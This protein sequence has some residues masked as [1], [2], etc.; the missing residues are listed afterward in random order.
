MLPVFVS[1]MELKY[2][3]HGQLYVYLMKIQNNLYW[4][5]VT[6]WNVST[7]I[8]ALYM[9]DSPDRISPFTRYMV[10][11]VNLS[12]TSWFY[13]MLSMNV[14]PLYKP[15]RR[16]AKNYVKIKFDLSCCIFTP[17]IM[18]WTREAWGDSSWILS[19]FSVSYSLNSLWILS[20]AAINPQC[21]H[22]TLMIF[23]MINNNM[24]IMGRMCIFA[25]IQ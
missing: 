4:S 18:K 6:Y 17:L 16:F 15:V 24:I 7:V 5:L 13:K 20:D 10:D 11:E 14:L 1:S 23:T 9:R 2:V 22:T 25:F 21:I 19:L 12:I 3:C 8:Q